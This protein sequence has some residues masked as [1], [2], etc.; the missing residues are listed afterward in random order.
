MSNPAPNRCLSLS[1]REMT[2]DDL[3]EVMAIERACFSMPWS[4][5]FF[6]REIALQFSIT[7]LARLE[8]EPET[9]AAGYIVMWFVADE[10]HVLNV[11]VNPEHRRRGVGRKLME[12]ALRCAAER[13]SAQVVLEVRVSGA[14]AQALYRSLGFEPIGMRSRYYADNGEDA[15]VMA[16]K[17]SDS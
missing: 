9:P 4:R 13:K 16:K 12:E 3:D 8:D 10:M 2:P 15:I 6:E 11:A 7:L 1:I 14:A 5:S 17:L